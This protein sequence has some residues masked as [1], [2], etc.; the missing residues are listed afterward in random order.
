MKTVLK[1]KRTWLIA[2]GAVLA[3]VLLLAAG[4]LQRQENVPEAAETLPS[5]AA[6]ETAA[7]PTVPETQAVTEAPAEVPTEA[8]EMTAVEIA[9][10]ADNE[11]Q[12]P[13]FTLYYPEAFADLLVVANTGKDPYVLEFY[14]MLEDRPEQRLFDVRLGKGLEGN[15]GIVKTD[16]GDIGVDMTIYAFTP[17]E[18]WT[19]G[20]TDTVLAMQDAANDM[21]ERLDLTEAPKKQEDTVVEQEKPESSILNSTDITTPYC[22]LEYPLIWQEYLV[23]EQTERPDGVCEVAF[24][25]KVEGKRKCLLFTFLFGGDE[26][27]QLGAL[28]ADDDSLVT[29][30]LLMAEPELKGW[31]EEDKQI[32][33]AMQEAVNDVIPWLPLVTE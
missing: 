14:A 10:F 12:T 27:D 7:A 2:G 21:L 8:E 3:V 4:L 6:E 29:V 32:I 19:R 20:E 5:A 28:L 9:E 11:I 25:G 22:T 31:R 16:A 17:G 23:V 30:N 18:D 26:G 33:Y 24:Y 15:M 1:N 13:W